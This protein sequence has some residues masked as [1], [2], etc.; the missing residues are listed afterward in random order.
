MPKPFSHDRPRRAPPPVAASDASAP[1][2]GAGRA[3]EH[4]RGIV[5]PIAAVHGCELVSVELRREP[6]GWV[7]RLYVERLGHDPRLSIG[8]VTLEDCTAISRDVSA[9]LDVH[10]VIDHAYHLEVSSP[11]LE[12]PLVKPADFA[13][14]AGF[15]ARVHLADAP[16]E[17][18]ARRGYK[19]VIVA[20]DEREVRFADDDLGEVVIPQASVQKA[21][22]VYE[23][24]PKP[25]PGKKAPKRASGGE[26]D[27]A[28]E[29]GQTSA[30]DVHHHARR[31]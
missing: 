18:P 30:S 20:A 3:V 16:E 4:V 29:P 22:L 9:A 8:G 25:K 6:V 1:Q 21:S 28:N 5:E 13:R 24:A 14:F 31:S 15:R 17:H 11:G 2:A 10:E 7:L 27:R 12:R 19:G 23:A 26:P